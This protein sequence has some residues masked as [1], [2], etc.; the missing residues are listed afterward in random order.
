MR[1]IR[2]LR[3]AFTLVM[4]RTFGRYIHSGW[5]GDFEYARYGWRGQEWCI[6]MAPYDENWEAHAAAVNARDQLMNAA[7]AASHALKSYEYGN[8]SPELAQEVIVALEA[9]LAK[10]RGEQ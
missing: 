8:S 6:P 4:A 2:T 7:Q 1:F 9:A 5:N 3:I 10:A